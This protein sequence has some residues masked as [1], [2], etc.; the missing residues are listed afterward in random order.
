M[1]FLKQGAGKRCIH[2]EGPKPLLHLAPPNGSRT[3]SEKY[4]YIKHGETQNNRKSDSGLFLTL[5]RDYEL[6]VDK[7][8]KHPEYEHFDSLGW[9]KAAGLVSLKY[10]I[11]SP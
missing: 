2:S 6:W 4:T 10:I 8:K 1:S 5:S 3:F 11:H 9:R 7:L